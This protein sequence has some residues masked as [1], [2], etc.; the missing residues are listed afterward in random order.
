MLFGRFVTFFK[1]VLDKFQLNTPS[2]EQAICD[3]FKITKDLVLALYMDGTYRIYKTLH[4]L[5]IGNW[6]YNHSDGFDTGIQ[7]AVTEVYLL[8]LVLV[9]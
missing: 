5:D 2:C 3:T 9:L 7:F 4:L 1:Q 8:L 6:K